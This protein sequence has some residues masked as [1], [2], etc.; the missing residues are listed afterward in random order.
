VRGVN[1]LGVTG[2]VRTRDQQPQQQLC[3]SFM[4]HVNTFLISWSNSNESLQVAHGG[5]RVLKWGRKVQEEFK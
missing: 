3:Q 4:F 1:V 2:V 5:K